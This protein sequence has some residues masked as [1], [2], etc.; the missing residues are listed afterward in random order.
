MF[1]SSS[2]TDN[3]KKEGPKNSEDPLERDFKMALE[4]LVKDTSARLLDGV[5]S[6]RLNAVVK[7]VS[8]EV[9]NVKRR[10]LRLHHTNA[11]GKNFLIKEYAF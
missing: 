8:V 9:Q 10:K 3:I 6:S 5:N 7:M 4:T 1:P 11:D 2:F